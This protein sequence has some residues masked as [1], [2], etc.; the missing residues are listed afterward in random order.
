MGS[1]F[2]GL[3]APLGGTRCLDELRRPRGHGRR[4]RAERQA[5]PRRF[6][7]AAR[8]AARARRELPVR[9][10]AT[11]IV[12]GASLTGVEVL[13]ELPNRLGGP[14]SSS[15]GKLTPY[16]GLHAVVRQRLPAHRPGR[17]AHVPA[18]RAVVDEDHPRGDPS[19]AEQYSPV[20]DLGPTGAVYIRGWDRTV[21]A[22]GTRAKATR[23][24]NNAAAAPQL[25]DRPGQP[26]R[27]AR[28][29]LS[30]AVARS[31]PRT[32][33]PCGLPAAGTVRPPTARACPGC[34]RP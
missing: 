20:L 5:H 27:I 22:R 34:G 33:A 11:N 10:T 28:P 29:P 31:P 21:I 4:H 13:C 17:S 24:T 2:A 3:W 14:L 6:D 12:V 8:T 18:D 7:G 16:P 26:V 19:R 9:A 25:Q 15:A 1:G 30:P 32:T 23:R